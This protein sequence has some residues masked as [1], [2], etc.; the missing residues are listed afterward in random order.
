MTRRWLLICKK[1][2]V[3]ICILFLKSCFQKDEKSLKKIKF[4]VTF[5]LTKNP[6]ML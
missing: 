1:R 6:P 4:F 3:F 5:L 2:R